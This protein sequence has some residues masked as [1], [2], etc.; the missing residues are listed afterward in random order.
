MLCEFAGTLDGFEPIH[1]ED[2]GELEIRAIRKRYFQLIE[3]EKLVETK[4]LKTDNENL[5]RQIS[6]LEAELN[7]LRQELETTRS[8]AQEERKHFYEKLDAERKEKYAVSNQLSEWRGMFIGMKQSL[9][10][11]GD[12][13]MLPKSLLN[14]LKSLVPEIFE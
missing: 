1:I 11:R 5:V 14:V 2:E 3:A 9:I 4:S 10:E 13:P 7:R 8:Y 6:Y 12:K